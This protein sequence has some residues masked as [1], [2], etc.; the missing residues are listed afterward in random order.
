MEHNV[1]VIHF[2]GARVIVLE[3]PV[4]LGGDAILKVEDATRVGGQGRREEL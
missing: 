4:V 3:V 2:H 1:L